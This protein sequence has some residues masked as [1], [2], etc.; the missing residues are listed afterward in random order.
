MDFWTLMC[1]RWL[2]MEPYISGCSASSV[3]PL[4]GRCGVG[5]QPP[6]DRPPLTLMV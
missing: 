4:P 5:Y 6:K 1:I 2:R 3:T